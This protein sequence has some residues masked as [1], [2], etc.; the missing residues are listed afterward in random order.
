MR[1]IIYK[2]EFEYLCLKLEIK[3]R[4]KAELLS[5]FQNT[6]YDI[7]EFYELKPE[8]LNYNAIK[9]K[10]RPVCNR[11]DSE[12]TFIK[13]IFTIGS[14]LEGLPDDLLQEIKQKRVAVFVGAGLSKLIS[15]E[16]P[17][18]GELADS[19]I[20]FLE[21]KG[22]INFFERERLKKEIPDPKQKLSIF[23]KYLEEGD[24]KGKD[25]SEFAEFMNRKLR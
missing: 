23:E 7:N 25:T 9:S 17:L 18:W 24:T 22:K 12:E 19:A 2:Y 15:R 21:E 6:P 3:D 5:M 16:Y 11:V 14:D 4:D 13:R 1:K 8:F 10:I 20:D